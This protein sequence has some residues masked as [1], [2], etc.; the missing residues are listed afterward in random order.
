MINRLLKSWQKRLP[1]MSCAAGCTF[2]CQGDA[3]AMTLAEW[4]EIQ[5][6]GKYSGGQVFQTCPFLEESGCGI[7]ARRPLLCRVFGTVSK[8]D[9][10]LQ[11]LDVP[12]FCP[13]GCEPEQPLPFAAA[14]KIQVDYQHYANRELMRVITD[15][16]R[17]LNEVRAG[18]PAPTQL[19]EKF[20]WLR[21]VLSTREGQSTLGM[22]W[23][24][25]AVNIDPARM[26]RLAGLVGG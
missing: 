11:G 13:K 25:K 23:G 20:A 18:T 1:A 4:R 14:L 6:P 10:D 15:W 12:I 7:Y 3:R 26:E 19:P 22:L 17:F 8:K 5:H 9:A 21:Y 24:A 16:A 2:C